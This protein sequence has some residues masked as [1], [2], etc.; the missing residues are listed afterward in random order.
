MP[1]DQW[2]KGLELLRERN[3]KLQFFEICYKDDD[4]GDPLINDD[5]AVN[6]LEVVSFEQLAQI[7]DYALRINQLLIN[8]FQQLILN[9]LIL[10][11]SLVLTLTI[12]LF[13]PMKLAQIVA[14]C[15]IKTV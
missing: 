15:G 9:L 1:L 5:H 13:W 4:L 7:K 10:K 14:D 8:I 3:C 12:K 11:L 2:L 6:V